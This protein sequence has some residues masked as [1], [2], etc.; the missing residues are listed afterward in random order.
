M[1]KDEMFDEIT[2]YIEHLVFARNCLDAYMSLHNNAQKYNDILNKA[3]GFFTIVQYSLS[4]CMILEFAKLFKKASANNKKE[5][6]IYKLLN[7]VKNSKNVFSNIDV[8]E[9]CAVA[10]EK[11][12]TDFKEV[13]QKLECRRDSDLTHNDH[14]FFSGEI[15]PAKENYIS[16][17]EFAT[18]YDFGVEFCNELLNALDTEKTIGLQ[19]GSNDLD[20]FLTEYSEC[21]KSINSK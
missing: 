9:L 3:P 4:K 1:N 2:A 20:N 16:P 11:L 17:I 7:I 13:I 6:T 15:N 19:F 8:L 10:E 14:K 18:L 12:A 21:I 5:R